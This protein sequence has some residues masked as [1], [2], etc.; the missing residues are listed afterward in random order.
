MPAEVI[1]TFILTLFFI[2]M[3]YF[4]MIL[5]E[6][7]RKKQVDTMR[8]SLTEG[9]DI[10]TIGGIT[11]R[12]C[13]VKESTLVIE[14]GADRV[15]LEIAKWAVANKGLPTGTGTDSSANSSSASK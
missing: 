9:E 1:Q 4:M 6:N 7:K 12:I 15:R 3:F 13:A 11:G 10:T 5:P 2:A 14:T 8:S